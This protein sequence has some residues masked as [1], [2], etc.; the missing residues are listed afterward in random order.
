M[1]DSFSHCG[2]PDIS[3]PSR[4]KNDCLL[5]EQEFI[6]LDL[7]GPQL[8]HQSIL[9]QGLP[10]AALRSRNVREGDDDNGHK[11][12]RQRPRLIASGARRRQ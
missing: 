1:V 9:P 11:Y 4:Y 10:G 5:A 2:I 8:E 6:K 7:T 12:E 3:V